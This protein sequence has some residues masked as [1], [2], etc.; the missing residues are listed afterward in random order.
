MSVN[1]NHLSAFH[2]HFSPSV[3]L[4]SYRFSLCFVRQNSPLARSS[5]TF[6][7]VLFFVFPRFSPDFAKPCHQNTIKP[8]PKSSLSHNQTATLLRHHT[9]KAVATTTTIQPIPTQL[10]S[11]NT[12]HDLTN[13]VCDDFVFFVFVRCRH[14]SLPPATIASTTARHCRPPTAARTAAS[15]FTRRRFLHR[16]DFLPHEKAGFAPLF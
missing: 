5:Q 15:L 12:F 9:K 13:H 14:P 8:H 11:L 2:G 16:A 10:K 1:I 7:P 4:R 3:F 6:L